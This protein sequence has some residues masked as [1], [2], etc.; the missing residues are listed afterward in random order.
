MV[1]SL[2][3][4]SK[5]ALLFFASLVSLLTP[6]AAIAD[7]CVELGGKKYC[8]S[9]RPALRPTVKPC[10]ETAP[11]QSRW[12]AW[13]NTTG[14]TYNTVTGDC[15]GGT[16]HT[17]GNVVSRSIAF[18]NAVRSSTCSLTSDTGYG[19]VFP[20][21][22]CLAGGDTFNQGYPTGTSRQL[23]IAC[24]NGTNETI[25][26]QKTRTLACP[27]GYVLENLPSYGYMCSRTPEDCDTCS[28]GN[29]VTPGTGVKTQADTDYRHA[30]GL[31]FTRHY[32]SFRFHDPWTD[33]ATQVQTQNQLGHV[34]RGSYDKRVI[35]LPNK[36][37]GHIARH[38]RTTPSGEVQ[39]FNSSGSEIYNYR[40][41][42]GTL[43]T[44]A[45]GF[46]YKGADS[47]EFYGTDGR[48]RTI[49]QSSGQLLT[50]TYSDGTTGANGG[51]ILDAAGSPTTWAL[52]ANKLI[53]V[54]DAFGNTLSFGY[55]LQGR[56]VVMTAPGSA[57]YRYAF[58]EDSNLTSVTFPDL[59]TRTYRYNEAANMVGGA[60][61][62][63][64]LTSVEDEKGNLYASFTYDTSGRALSTEHAGGAQRHEL[65]YFGNGWTH[66]ED[67]LG[68]SRAFGF[69]TSEGIARFTG[70]NYKGGA[71]YGSGI[72]QRTYDSV[73]NLSSQTD[74]NDVK[75]CY[76]YLS[77][78]NL[79]TVRVEGLPASTTCSTVV[80]TGATLP[81]G[82]RK[83]ITEWHSRWRL[84]A[85]ISEPGRRT[86]FGYNGDPSLSC[87][88]SG[89]VI[90]E[91]VTPARPIGVLCSKTTQ[92]TT[93]TASG[94]Q[95][96]SA[97]LT[98]TPRTLNFTYNSH[99]KVLTAK[100]ARTDISTDVTTYTYYSDTDADTAKR[101]N[102]ATITNAAGHLTSITSYNAHGQPLTIVDPNGV[103]TTLVYDSRQR[104]TSRTASGET[105]TY[106]YD[107]AG[108]LEK[109]ILPDTS[110]VSYIYDNAH[111][112]KEIV[113]KA[114]NRIVYTLDA[115]GNRTKEDVR[116][117]GSV[118][119]R[120][121]TRVFDGYNRLVYEAHP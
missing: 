92:A 68:T 99:G 48:L 108:L 86:T 14:G 28:V 37:C 90:D 29:G 111:R 113:D 10:D 78:R 19:A 66:V 52:P 31:Y 43:V 71:G 60:S 109:I 1:L 46:Y 82:S 101:G 56:V 25:S 107:A 23:S 32:H 44:T 85:R 69:A 88:P 42:S 17:D 12:I 13:C 4:Q 65:T 120:T 34:W 80:T 76:A 30:S 55:D 63:Y 104:L 116:D 114:D 87:A 41:A 24:A 5:A 112:L 77:A 72:K 38:A 74:F 93:D 3:P 9:Q 98:G 6:A 67:P 21:S 33:A 91:G 96:F 73:G 97:T 47:T 110:Y 115:M 79:E 2:R 57:I 89:A 50:L 45:S 70:A 103:T 105:I 83:I 15:I 84:P 51:Y 20:S 54:A 100:G 27:V 26:I 118:L 94:S 35:P 75:T 62:A 81:A 119:R 11:Q 18:A 8:G 61:I 106:D 58:D 117:P 102:L 121:L 36:C 49:T 64:A 40:G 22:W 7:S 39:Y 59:R 95:G 16:P 53:R